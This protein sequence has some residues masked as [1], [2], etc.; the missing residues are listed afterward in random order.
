MFSFLG[1]LIIK[2]VFVT[3][4]FHGSAKNT[5]FCETLMGHTV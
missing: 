5:L 2:T 1:Q 3:W 4:H